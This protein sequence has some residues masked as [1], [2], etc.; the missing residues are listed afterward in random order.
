[1]VNFIK[2]C[3]TEGK[4]NWLL[5]N[6]DL[7]LLKSLLKGKNGKTFRLER[8]ILM[9]VNWREKFTSL[10]FNKYL[11]FKYIMTYFTKKRFNLSE[12]FTKRLRI[13]GI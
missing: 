4:G 11:N 10:S 12:T 9:Q 6:A 1:M 2:Y 8:G 5:Q 7:I 3:K 13:A